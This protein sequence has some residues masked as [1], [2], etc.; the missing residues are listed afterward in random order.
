MTVETGPNRDDNDD[1]T[2]LIANRG[3]IAVRIVRTL[4]R[5]G[6][7]S[8]AIYSDGDP[9]S[10]H[11]TVADDAVRVGGA[12][13]ADSYLDADAIIAAAQRSG[14]GM[15]HPGYG[16]LSENASFA[17]ACAEAGL[18]FVG[19]PPEAI[20]AMG[21][22]ISAKATVAEAG[23]PLLPG[24]AETSGQAMSDGDF[25]AAASDVGFP[26]LIK[27]SAGGGGKGMR[28]VQSAEDLAAATAAARREAKAA[29]GDATLLVERLLQRPRHIEVQVLADRHG[30]VVHLGERECS[31][32]RRH[33]KIVE[34]APSPLL[35]EEQRA[36]MGAA[37]VAAAR[38]CNYV[39]AGTVEFIVASPDP[40]S[41]QASAQPLEYSFLEMN[42]RLQVEHPVTEAVVTVDGSP[43]DLVELQLRVA[44]GEPLPFSQERIVLHGH[45]VEA[46]IYAEDPANDFLPTGGPVLLL[47]EPD[48]PGVRVD[49]GISV[50]E[51]VTT[52]YDPM[53][54]K[55]VTKAENRPAAL[56]RMDRALSAYTLLG[57]G[58]NVDFLRRLLRHPE[59][60][61]AHLSTEL[62]EQV[63]A[64]VLPST[65]VH[66]PLEC[67]VAAAIGRQLSLH[68]ESPSGNRFAL[69]DGWRL[70]ERA[71]TTWRFQGT[72][73]SAPVPV[74][75]RPDDTAP[76]GR[77]F[78]A[79]VADT[80]LGRVMVDRCAAGTELRLTFEE[81]SVRYQHAE[82]D[83]E[84]WLGRDGATWRLREARRLPSLRVNETVADGTVRSPMPG[85]VLSVAVPPNSHV[86]AG[87]A[88]MVV[89]AMKME[90]TITAPVSGVLTQLSAHPGTT[91]AM[92]AVLAVITPD[93][94][95]PDP[96]R[97]T[98]SHEE[99]T[100]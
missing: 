15:I 64:D 37:A 94:Q 100:P 93:P 21:D 43:V 45:A 63:R 50:G 1:N 90:H 41:D 58:T 3:E 71:E 91:V 78:D 59:V 31:L 28:I 13:L 19:P 18:V 35:T 84:I 96:E 17:R 40:Y 34:E 83:G 69:P 36:E 8:V 52:S 70:G 5:L 55:L 7:R 2:V 88:L 47:H 16:F 46:R 73:D 29:F 92:D 53:L 77:A 68:R 14:A 72:T 11:V 57:C 98:S 44:A 89:E 97:S 23:V 20:E 33:Q 25:A 30:N 87:S 80:R 32:Q 81:S 22:K 26:L 65:A 56:A 75:L 10:T 60:R 4:R 74:H 51:T 27:P 76:A 6:M 82:S 86:E 38:A 49:S 24:F 39:G 85:T 67:Y 54:A 48:L 61:S 99:H 95:N 66:P 12:R 79:T 42:T 62:T 9:D